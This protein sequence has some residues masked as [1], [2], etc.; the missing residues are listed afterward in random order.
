MLTIKTLIIKSRMTTNRNI[1]DHVPGGEAG[2]E[3]IS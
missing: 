3:L 1:I 2:N